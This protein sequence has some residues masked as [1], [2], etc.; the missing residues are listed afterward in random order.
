MNEIQKHNGGGASIHKI[1]LNN[2]ILKRTGRYFADR[3]KVFRRGMLSAWI[4]EL[5]NAE[6]KKEGY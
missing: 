4:N 6:L 5:M 1:A 3:G 2:E